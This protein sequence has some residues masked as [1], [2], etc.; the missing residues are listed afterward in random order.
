MRGKGWISLHRKMLDNPV[1]CKDGDHVAVWVYLLL[2]ATH[3]EYPALFAGNKITLKPG[4]LITGRKVIAEKFNISES[5]VQRILKSF[6]S[7]QQIEQQN[8]NKNRLISI[9]SWEDYQ[10]DERQNEQQLNN[11]RTTTEQQEFKKTEKIEQQNEQ[12]EGGSNPCA[13][14]DHRGEEDDS[15]QQNEQQLNNKNSD[16][17]EKVNTNNNNNN[18]FKEN[19]VE[20]VTYLN[21]RVGAS[22]S[23]ETKKTVSLINGRLNE[24][25]TIEDF[26]KVID[27]K[28][29]EW[30]GKEQE[31]Y[32][33]PNTLFT[34]T[35]FENYLNQASRRRKSKNPQLDLFEPSEEEL[36][37]LDSIYKRRSETST[38]Q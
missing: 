22:Y 28:T 27:I 8:S 20:I 25:R 3:A 19:I 10:D 9:R 13:Y 15:E 34:P 37:H 11:K 5:K 24:G 23:S 31:K 35:N 14:S 36:N 12:Q 2:N 32:L 16:E 26:K 21:E 1:V 18:V 4:Q 29:E 6:E 7:E 38:E 17:I 33:R 30:L